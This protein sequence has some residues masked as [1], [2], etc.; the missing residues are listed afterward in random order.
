MEGNSKQTAS[1]IDGLFQQN[2][3]KSILQLNGNYFLKIFKKL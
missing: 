2:V 3:I 1:S